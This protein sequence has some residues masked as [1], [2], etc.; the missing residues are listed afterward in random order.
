MRTTRCR[1]MGGGR[2]QGSQWA[3][4]F[5]GAIEATR[6]EFPVNNG[7]FGQIGR[8]GRVEENRQI[9]TGDPEATF[10]QFRALITRGAIKSDSN[11]VAYGETFIFSDGSRV[12]ARWQSSM[13]SGGSQAIEIWSYHRALAP[14]QKI[15]FERSPS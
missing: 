10:N 6:S 12:T 4:G 11:G 5:A 8:S 14:Y 3:S 15:H 13:G 2:S 1:A 9:F 7:F